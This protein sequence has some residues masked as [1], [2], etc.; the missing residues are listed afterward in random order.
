[1]IHRD[2]NPSNV[3]VQPDDQI[4]ILDFGLSCPAG[5]EDFGNTGT[6]QYMA[7]E[8]IDADP[9]DGR[10]DIYALGI[11]AYEMVTG[12]LPFVN[13]DLNTL[14]KM[15]TTHDIPDP[16]ELVPDIPG[17]LRDFILTAGRCIPR[18]RYASMGHAMEALDPLLSQSKPIKR[19][20]SLNHDGL[21]T[22]VLSYKKEQQADLNRLLASFRT[23]AQALGVAV[24]MADYKN[25]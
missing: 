15:H 12:R 16:A 3:I 11:T 4:K 22:L 5:T 18:K 20:K 24:K 1:I 9:V 2:I 10:T 6:A 13:S 17:E 14:L 21:S 7:P 25:M 19:L 23:Q 8:Q